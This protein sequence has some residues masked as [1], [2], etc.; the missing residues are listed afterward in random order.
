MYGNINSTAKKP[1]YGRVTI[2][3]DL[4]N[5]YVNILKE[6]FLMDEMDKTAPKESVPIYPKYRYLSM[7]VIGTDSQGTP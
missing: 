2:V 7:A 1:G 4:S 3:K 6:H 5:E